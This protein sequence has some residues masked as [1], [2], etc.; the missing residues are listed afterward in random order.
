MPFLGK[1]YLIGLVVTAISSLLI[2][3]EKATARTQ[4]GRSCNYVRSLVGAR[5]PS[6][7]K[8]EIECGNN[9]GWVKA[10]QTVPQKVNLVVYER[11]RTQTVTINVPSLSNR[12]NHSLERYVSMG[13]GELLQL[14]NANGIS[15]SPLTNVEIARNNAFV[16]NHNTPV[17]DHYLTTVA[18]V[19][20]IGT[21]GDA[22]WGTGTRKCGGQGCNRRRDGCLSGYREQCLS[23]DGPP[24]TQFQC[25]RSN[26]TNSNVPAELSCVYEDMPLVIS[27][28]CSANKL[29]VGRALCSKNGRNAST[30]LY[31]PANRGQ[32]P[33]ATSCALADT[34]SEYGQ[35]HEARIANPFGS[36]SSSNFQDSSRSGGAQ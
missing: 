25:T 11:G 36:T 21:V 26:N 2:L 31:C 35:A 28:G 19:N 29:C 7:A 4:P 17:Y 33:T 6:D 8:V 16:L 9:D 18:G 14:L 15:T 24:C 30:T 10:D 5:T 23:R 34:P 20:Q 22:V 13:R 1:T 12:R 27:N 3:G 32:C